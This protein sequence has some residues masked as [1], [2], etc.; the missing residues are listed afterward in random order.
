MS[1]SDRLDRVEKLLTSV[2]HSLNEIATAT[3]F[4]SLAEAQTIAFN[5]CGTKV[6][7]FVPNALEDVIQKALL[8]TGD[9]VDMK[10]FNGLK[11]LGVHFKDAVI[12]DVGANIGNHSI[13]FSLIGE[14]KKVLAFEPQPYCADLFRKNLILNNLTNVD[15]FE[16]ALGSFNGRMQISSFRANNHGATRFQSS[17]TGAFSCYRLDDFIE[18]N[19]LPA[20]DLIKIDAEGNGPD[21]MRGA[22]ETICKAKPFIWTELWPKLGELEPGFAF[23]ESCGYQLFKRLSRSDYLF[24]HP[25]NPL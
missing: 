8:M 17:E 4:S 3:R 11:A 18:S 10:Y 21:V 19:G 14:A 13:Y 12:Y 22:E 20:P 15:V 25:D 9:F 1:D 16:T 23:M 2:S 24:V 7:F 6:K 5:H